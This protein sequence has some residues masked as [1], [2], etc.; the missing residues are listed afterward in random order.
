MTTK[1]KPCPF[2][3]A[4]VGYDGEMGHILCTDC[5]FFYDVP[6]GIKE[7]APLWNRRA[8]V[9]VKEG[10]DEGLGDS[11]EAWEDEAEAFYKTTGM[12][13]PGKDVAA[14]SGWTEER[15]EERQKAY[16]IWCA[17]WS[18]RD[19]LSRR[20]G[21]AEVKEGGEYPDTVLVDKPA[22]A[23]AGLVEELGKRI[24]FEIGLYSD[25]GCQA[26]IIGG[27][28]GGFRLSNSKASG[29]WTLVRK[30]KCSASIGEMFPEIL[31]KYS[32]EA[33]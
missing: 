15:E 18:Y 1:L 13:R 9:P 3:G 22:P 17:G 20:P 6:T 7:I 8:A 12:L 27:G 31:A 5:G 21:K 26:L 10:G 33:K 23:E 25:S 19:G 32:K 28:G 16:K 29:S 14:A 11:L 24:D 4:D 2:C 30:F